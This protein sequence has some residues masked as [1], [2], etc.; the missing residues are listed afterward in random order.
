MSGEIKE[1]EVFKGIKISFVE[2]LNDKRVIK[3]YEDREIWHRQGE[4]YVNKVN[5]DNIQNYIDENENFVKIDYASDM[6]N[7]NGKEVTTVE[8]IS[9]VA[10]KIYPQDEEVL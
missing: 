6:S 2:D 8:A 5:P 3:M 4:G 7:I 1:I 9:F 10:S